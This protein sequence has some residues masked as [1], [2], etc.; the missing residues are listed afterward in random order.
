[1]P[2]SGTLTQIHHCS[3]GLNT[4]AT[5]TTGEQP[6]SIC[7]RSALP[8]SIKRENFQIYGTRLYFKARCQG[9]IHMYKLITVWGHHSYHVKNAPSKLECGFSKIPW[10]APVTLSTW[11]T[12]QSCMHPSKQ[13]PIVYGCWLEGSLWIPIFAQTSVAYI[14]L[15]LTE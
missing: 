13:H 8:V 9:D 5:I 6:Q 7:R 15:S 4:F 2:F 10:E 3:T 12:W 11:R 14:G 1:M